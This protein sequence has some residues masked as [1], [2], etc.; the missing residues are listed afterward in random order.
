MLS[1]DV[2]SFKERSLGQVLGAVVRQRFQVLRHDE[3]GPLT[4]ALVFHSH[5]LDAGTNVV[6]TLSRWLPSDCQRF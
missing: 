3:D 2:I 6:R 1:L 5:F 4:D